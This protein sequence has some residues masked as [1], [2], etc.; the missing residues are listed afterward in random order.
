MLKFLTWD[1]LINHRNHQSGPDRK[2][3]ELLRAGLAPYV[4]CQIQSAIKLGTFRM[5]AVRKF[6]DDSMLGK[7]PILQCD[8]AGVLKLMWETWNDMFRKTLGFSERSLVSEME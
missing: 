2:G 4:E 1:K 5:D 6:P 3:I 8:A 7:K